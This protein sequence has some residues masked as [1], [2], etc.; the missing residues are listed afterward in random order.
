MKIVFF[1]QLI[2]V[3]GI[4]KITKKLNPND[5]ICDLGLWCQEL[6][7][8]KKIDLSE[9]KLKKLHPSTFNGLINLEELDPY[10]FEDLE[11]D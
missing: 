7:N 10:L 9:N 5:L 11:T 2:Q 6:Q 8:L 4:T 3:L 1:S